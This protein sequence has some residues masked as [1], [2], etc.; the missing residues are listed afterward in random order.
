MVRT[1]R[2]IQNPDTSNLARG[3]AEIFVACVKLLCL[4]P[5]ILKLDDFC[6]ILIIICMH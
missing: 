6:L 2:I 3:K 5:Q 4:A 1:K